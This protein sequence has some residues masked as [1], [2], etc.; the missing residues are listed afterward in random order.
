MKNVMEWGPVIWEANLAQSIIVE[1]IH[2]SM[3]PTHYIS[4]AE[5][6]FDNI[7]SIEV[8]AAEA[9]NHVARWSV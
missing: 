6:H 4:T 2:P 7:S 1:S 5:S 3:I 8:N 9:S